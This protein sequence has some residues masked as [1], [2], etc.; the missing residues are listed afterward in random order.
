MSLDFLR[1]RYPNIELPAMRPSA[2]LAAVLLAAAPAA[3]QNQY[4]IYGPAVEVTIADLSSGGVAYANRAVKTKGWL[5]RNMTIDNTTGSSGRAYRLRDGAG[6][7]VDILP[8]SQIS[9]EFDFQ[10]T[11]LLGRRVEVEGLFHEASSYITD[12]G[13][14]SAG[15]I[16]FWKYVGLPDPEEERLNKARRLTIEEVVQAKGRH[17]GRTARIVGA[18]RGHNLFEDLPAKT[19]RGR[20]DW[21]LQHGEYALW[22]TGRKPRGD[23]WELDPALKRDTG[24]WIEVTGKI[25]TKNDVVYVRAE[26]LA[27]TSEP[28]EPF[29]KKEVAEVVPE[30]PRLPPVVVFSL[31]L[32]GEEEVPRDSRFVVQFNNDMDETSFKGRVELRYVSAPRV[33]LHPLDTVTFSYEPGRRALTV[34]PGNTLGRGTD[35]ELRLLPGIKDINGLEL[36]PRTNGLPDG[37][38][39]A[40]RY[41]VGL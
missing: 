15:T 27:L 11:E 9:S 12:P 38:V 24:K 37:V 16:E 3:A 2:A 1:L 18:F 20:S 39:D 13:N 28:P 23:G 25:E 14:R 31:P 22:V 36:V 41:H 35:L 29:V 8:V 30:R 10:A 4:D 26:R 21:V 34:D 40:L 19:A 6:Y 32:D 7:T 33:G 5:E 17:D